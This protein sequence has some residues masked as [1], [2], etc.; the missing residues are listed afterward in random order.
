MQLN[1]FAGEVKE[2]TDGPVSLSVEIAAHVR[3]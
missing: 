2:G 1:G 3:G